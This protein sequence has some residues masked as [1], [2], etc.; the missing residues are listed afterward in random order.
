MRPAADRLGVG[1][2][3]DERIGRKRQRLVEQEQREQ[4]LG[5]G[6][7]DR[8]AQRHG[9][10]DIVGGLPRLVVAPHVA[11]GIDRVHDPEPGGNQRKEHSERLDLE[12]ERE[13]RHHLDIQR[14][15]AGAGKHGT[16]QAE[17]RQ[18]ERTGRRKRDRLA[19]VGHAVEH[20]DQQRADERDQ[21]GSEDED[22]RRVGE[23]HLSPPMSAC[24]A[25]LATPA[26]SSVKIPK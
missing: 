15:G 11:D 12:R 21:D 1:L 6:D 17:H 23:H 5:E 20:R 14:F 2:V 26:D 18:E 9:E 13:P 10:A 19:Q 4:V 7:A 8:A 16:E 24:A 3:G 25:L 22:L